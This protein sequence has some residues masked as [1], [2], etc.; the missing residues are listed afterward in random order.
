MMRKLFAI[1]MAMMLFCMT[2]LAEPP[3]MTV[4]GTGVVSVKPDTATISLGVREAAKD[5]SEAQ[6]AVSAKVL[7]VVETLEGMGVSEDDI[8]TN[9][10][11]VYMDYDYDSSSSNGVR[12]YI[13]ENTVSVKVTDVEN[14]G[15]YI[16]AAFTAGANTFN[17]IDFSASDTKAEKKQAMELSVKNAREKAEIL[18]AAAGMRI[19]GIQAIR[20]SGGYYDMGANSDALYA[21]AETASGAATPVY[22]DDIQVSAT[23]SIDFTMAPVE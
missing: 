22:A 23:V 7:D 15:K 10:L 20:E 16:D 1:L 18:A 13:A 3:V 8:H 19:S 11:Y 2:A 6:S 12:G 21:K 4:T 9:S 17:G 14:V 5:V